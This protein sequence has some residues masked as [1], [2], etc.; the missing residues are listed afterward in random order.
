MSCKPKSLRAANGGELMERFVRHHG[1]RMQ[2]GGDRLGT[3]TWDPY[4]ELWGPHSGS[5]G[6]SLQPAQQ[7][8]PQAYPT[9]LRAGA[10]GGLVNPPL[11]GA[12]AGAGAGAERGSINPPLAQPVTAPT[13]DVQWDR[14]TNTFSNAEGRAMNPNFSGKAVPGAAP[15]VFNSADVLKPG[16]V[17]PWQGAGVSENTDALMAGVASRSGQASGLSAGTTATPLETKTYQH[18]SIPNSFMAAAPMRHGGQL[19]M[20]GSGPVPGK[21]KGDKIPAKYEPGEFVVS[22]DMLKA[23]P[24]LRDHLHGLRAQV[25]AQKGMTPAMADARTMTPRGLRAELSYAGQNNGI[26]YVDPKFQRPGIPVPPPYV[27]PAVDPAT[28]AYLKSGAQAG[29]L[30][31]TTTTVPAGTTPAAPTDYRTQVRDAYSKMNPNLREP[32]VSAVKRGGGT[33]GS[34]ARGAARYAPWLAAATDAADVVDVATDPKMRGRDTL[35]EVGSKA[36][37]WGAATLAGIG[38]TAATAPFLGPFAP[39]AGIG[40][41]ALTYYGTG[42]AIQG[43]RGAFGAETSDPSSRSNGIVNQLINGSDEGQRTSVAPAAAAAAQ[44]AAQPAASAAQPT[45]K[46]DGISGRVNVIP[47]MSKEQID[48]ELTNPD[49][50]R[51]NA[52][53]NARMAA[54]LRDGV[55]QYRGTSRGAALD[56][57]QPGQ[58]GYRGYLAQKLLQ[59]QLDAQREGHQLTYAAAMAPV[60]YAAIQRG[61]AAQ[62][63]N[64]TGGDYG[65]AMELALRSGVDP[66]HLQAAMTAQTGFNTANQGLRTSEQNQREGAQAS[67]T[68]LLES[69]Y[70]GP[71]GKPDQA[72]VAA[73]RAAIASH[74][75]QKI[76][77]IQTGMAKYPA[78]HEA[79]VTGQE[80]IDELRTQ[81]EAGMSPDMLQQILIG[82][83][84]KQRALNNS[85]QWNPLQGTFKDSPEPNAYRVK[86]KIKGSGLHPDM[87]ET[88][89]GSMVPT[90]AYDYDNEGNMILPNMWGNHP[91]TR[92]QTI[93]AR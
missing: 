12:G 89:N 44:P 29:P 20:H 91:T 71:D 90:R 39:L 48:Q 78:G 59:M 24:Q 34:L 16:Q 15:G 66:S 56:V 65:K 1:L 88:N 17:A 32:L 27:L 86:R 87:Y 52:T 50:S 49:G 69:T 8:P 55:D 76:N 19:N 67:I 85:S 41:G 30:Q 3:G 31:S 93:G 45:T 38:T 83:D 47:A 57:P 11:A 77:D 74:L 72:K 7:I 22:N 25:L 36:G 33:L 40:A 6:L 10:G 80:K 43:A 62:L 13:T 79:R 53:D 21:G 63:L 61:L 84:A 60:K 73:A 5:G 14:G 51:W 64:S 18:S 4:A 37:K 75:N 70:A 92:F 28:G 82:A 23:E 58:L 68:K 2:S 81:G 35:T 42:K 46:D 9:R 54:N 26:D